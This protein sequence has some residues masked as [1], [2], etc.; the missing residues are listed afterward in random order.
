MSDEIRPD[1][2]MKDLEPLLKHV[3]EDR[4]NE[5]L[6][7]DSLFFGEM[8]KSPPLTKKQLLVRK[9]KKFW[10]HIPDFFHYLK[11]Y[12]YENWRYWDKD[13]Y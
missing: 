8:F 3:Y 5:Y 7:R 10:N 4:I 11:Q 13:G 12:E 9:W 6:K 2:S 1:M